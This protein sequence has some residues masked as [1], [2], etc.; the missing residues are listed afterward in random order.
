VRVNLTVAGQPLAAD[1]TGQAV[2]ELA[3]RPGLA[4]RA[5]FKATQV[6]LYGR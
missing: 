1:L 6:R 3:L 2:A 5:A 4:V